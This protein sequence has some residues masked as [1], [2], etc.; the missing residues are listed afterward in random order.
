MAMNEIILLTNQLEAKYGSVVKAPKDDPLLL[1]LQKLSKPT[2][3]GKDDK[4][5]QLIK[6]GYSAGEIYQI[7]NVKQP[8]VQRVKDFLNLK[9]KPIFKYKL[10][11]DGCPDGYTPYVGGMCKLVG[12]GKPGTSKQIKNKIESLGYEISPIF[13]H[14]GDLP[15]GAHYVTRNNPV[16]VKHG[17]DSWLKME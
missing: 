3:A 10:T 7:L 12:I 15:D 9:Y 5:E 8:D 1:K 6:Y 2:T 11:K 17:L 16:L 14:W 13:F 4:I